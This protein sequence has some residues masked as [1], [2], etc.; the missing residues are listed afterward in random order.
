MLAPCTLNG[1]RFRS[2]LR[3]AH[4]PHGGSPVTLLMT[5]ARASPTRRG[6]VLP[7]FDGA[8]TSEML[9]KVCAL[10]IG[11]IRARALAD[12]ITLRKAVG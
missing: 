6:P 3:D 2:P 4:P 7:A 10:Q 11:T 5:D 1:S 12:Q 8:I 9:Q